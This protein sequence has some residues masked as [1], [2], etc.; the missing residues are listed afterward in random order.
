MIVYGLE[1]SPIAPTQSNLIA[2]RRVNFQTGD[3]LSA[4]WRPVTPFR[5]TTRETPTRE[6]VFSGAAGAGEFF[7]ATDEE[8]LSATA[9]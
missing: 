8:P 7:S 3:P 2:M 4:G 9:S 6:G 5:P 1:G